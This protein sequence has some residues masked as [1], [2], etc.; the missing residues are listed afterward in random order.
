MRNK[1]LDLIQEKQRKEKR[2]IS[3]REIAARLGISV[4]TLKKW[5]KQDVGR[6]DDDIVSAICI[7]FEI[8]EPN[9]L[10][11]FEEVEEPA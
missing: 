9:Q 6:Y 7:Y 10:F 1:L 4:N 8:D 2:L 3:Q 5:I 11:Y